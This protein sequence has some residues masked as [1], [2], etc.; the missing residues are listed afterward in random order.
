MSVLFETGG[1]TPVAIQTT[2]RSMMTVLAGAAA[3]ME[4]ID[5]GVD[6]DGSAAASGILVE[7]CLISTLGTN[8]AITLRPV[9]S[10]VTTP[11]FPG[12]SGYNC[13]VEPTVT[14][15]I[16]QHEVAPTSGR[17]L[18]LPEGGEFACAAS[19]GFGIRVTGA[20]SNVPKCTPV[21]RIRI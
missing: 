18:W 7:L 15:V 13:T 17:E 14:Y 10:R 21:M 4:L 9:D 1:F 12:T 11:S 20:A 19:T 5:W 2:A 16:R 6:F 3:G 8:T